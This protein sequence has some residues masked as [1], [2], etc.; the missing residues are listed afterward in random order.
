[1][2]LNPPQASDFIYVD[3][4]QKLAAEMG[5]PFLFWDGYDIA[6]LFSQE[7]PPSIVV[8]GCCDAGLT[9]QQQHHPSEDLLKHVWATDWD[10]LRQN[11][12]QYH[13][14]HI[15]PAAREGHCD[16]THRY[17]MKTDR[18]TWCTFDRFPDWMK[19]WYSP[20]CNVDDPRVHCVPF[21]LNTDG[22]GSS[23]LPEYQGREKTQ[24]LYCNFQINSTRRVEVRERYR[25]CP[26]VTFQES[27]NLPVRN[28]L[29]ELSRHKFALAPAGN[30]LDAYRILECIY[31]GVV[32]IVE[33]SYWASHML[34]MK[35]PIVIMRDCTQ[36]TA[37]NLEW[38]WEHINKLAFDYK[39]VTLSR[40]RDHFLAAARSLS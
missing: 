30:G 24:L 27:P 25:D 26:F 4:W 14:V 39:P 10:G 33:E 20:N 28:Y 38:A 31:L 17:S 13:R 16:P 1:V 36:L 15:G 34:A 23:Y 3:T 7:R 12:S 8:T 5:S 40:W 2:S 21:G 32:P 35:L 19:A 22:P 37:E 29:D 9:Y 18:F 6:S 11:K